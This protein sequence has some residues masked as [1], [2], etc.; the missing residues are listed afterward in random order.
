MQYLY[1]SVR[2]SCSAF[3]LAVP[4]VSDSVKSSTEPAGICAE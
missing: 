3:Q 1:N 4:C 2:R